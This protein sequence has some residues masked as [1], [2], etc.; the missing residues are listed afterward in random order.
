M[1]LASPDEPHRSPNQS[2]HQPVTPIESF[3]ESIIPELQRHLN[4]V[5]ARLAEE[6]R[7]LSLVRSD[8]WA[9]QTKA[10][11]SHY[12]ALRF[13]T[14]R[15]SRRWAEENNVWRLGIV[16]AVPPTVGTA[17]FIVSD[18][19]IDSVPWSAAIACLVATGSFASLKSR[20]I[21]LTVEEAE[22]KRIEHTTLEQN[23]SQR[24]KDLRERERPIAE[25]YSRLSDEAESLS[26][27]LRQLRAIVSQR[28]REEAKALEALNSRRR[29]EERRRTLYEMNW[30]AM[31]SVEFEQYLILVFKELGY[32]VTD[33]Q[34]TG[35]QGVDLIVADGSL[36][37]AVQV[38][39]YH[40]SV[41]NS[42][43]QEA[44]AGMAFYQ[45]AMCAVITNS[46]FTPSAIELAQKV[47]CLMIHEDNFQKF[48]M[49]QIRLFPATLT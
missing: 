44:F 7:E 28:K 49:G 20:Y 4:E 17:L 27:R 37:L 25:R 42:A 10:S 5:A 40:N 36:R 32:S 2:T 15:N 29:T 1:G 11:Q 41:G 39:G 31:R 22:R 6:S 46:R 9:E 13:E 33:T 26:A 8:I 3:D 24:I 34:V 43:V 35:D 19:F 12:K 45:C 23:A 18:L 14:V 16:L 30:K 48:V 21:G 38:K 47:N